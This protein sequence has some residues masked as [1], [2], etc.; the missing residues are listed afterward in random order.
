MTAST[1]PDLGSLPER[2]DSE[3]DACIRWGVGRAAAIAM[4]SLPTQSQSVTTSK[5]STYPRSYR[6]SPRRGHRCKSTLTGDSSGRFRSLLHKSR[7]V[8]CW[9]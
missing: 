4:S 3:A 5:T 1:N 2:L 8:A 6:G 7:Q 9:E